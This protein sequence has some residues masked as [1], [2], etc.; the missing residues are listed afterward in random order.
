MN[1]TTQLLERC[2]HALIYNDAS[3]LELLKDIDDA[4]A[5]QQVEQEP[6][7]HEKSPEAC[8]RVRCQLG[9]KC[10]NDD[11]SFRHTPQA[12]KQVEQEPVYWDVLYCGAHVKNVH[13]SKSEAE[14]AMRVLNAKHEGA[15]KVVPIYN[16]PDQE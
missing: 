5:K 6:C 12:P 11:L 14:E 10:M 1:T 9:K 8:Y 16:K 7:V 13:T 4:I 15:R 3:D 2:K